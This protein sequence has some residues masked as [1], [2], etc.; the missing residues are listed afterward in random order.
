MP[1]LMTPTGREPD[2]KTQEI[3]DKTNCVPLVVPS[4]L[5]TCKLFSG[6]LL[7]KG[8]SDVTHPDYPHVSA[9]PAGDSVGLLAFE[10]AR[11][12]QGPAKIAVTPLDAG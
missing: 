8:E 10:T 12:Y 2:E 1:E 6:C 9:G 11:V 7:Q 3:Q 5:P 4:S